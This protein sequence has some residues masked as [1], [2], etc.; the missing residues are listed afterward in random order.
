MLLARGEPTWW[1]G[2]QAWFIINQDTLIWLLVL[3][4]LLWILT[5]RRR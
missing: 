3:G 5:A 4:I 1:G 2:V